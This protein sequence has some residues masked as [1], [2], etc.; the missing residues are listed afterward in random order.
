MADLPLTVTNVGRTALAAAIASGTNLVVTTQK[1]GQGQ[2]T[3]DGDEIDIMTPFVPVREQMDPAGSSSG[4]TLQFVFQD[5]SSDVYD[6][7]EIGWF[8][9]N[10]LFGISSR[11]SSEGWLLQKG[12]LPLVVP[13]VYDLG[14]VPTGN[15]VFNVTNQFPIATEQTPGLVQRA[16]NTQAL[17]STN[18]AVFM[19]PMRTDE[20]FQSKEAS[21]NEYDTNTAGKWIASN[22]SIL[23]T[24]LKGT[25]SAARF[26]RASQTEYNA[27]TR[28]DLLVTANLDVPVAKLTGSIPV[29]LFPN[30]SIGN[31]SLRVTSS[32]QSI[33]GSKLNPHIANV[34]DIDTDGKVQLGAG[35][36]FPVLVIDFIPT[37]GGDSRYVYS[38]GS[39]NGL[40]LHPQGSA[41]T[42]SSGDKIYL[43]DDFIGFSNSS[44]DG[45][46][47][48]AVIDGDS[49][50]GIYDVIL[51]L[52]GAFTLGLVNPSV[53][54]LVNA[55]NIAWNWNN[56]EIATLVITGNRTLSV[57]TN[58]RN[59]SLYL[60][61][62]TQDSIGTRT[63][64][65][66]ASIAIGE[67]PA[68]VLS[69]TGGRTDVLGFMKWNGT[70]NYMGILKGY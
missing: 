69:T 58:G 33:G 54:S 8:S 50:T 30:R 51:D 66:H 52:F 13:S 38:S 11:P 47:V 15:I 65:L 35:T 9:G 31:A 20:Y 25:I 26:P 16:S 36:N 6:I 44:S 60:L 29:S 67:S 34:V 22:L 57:P 46:P 5:P 18:N 27:G 3:P 42:Y 63:L 43:R 14:D 61:R 41:D 62:I 28:D 1:S 2:Y 40:K 24:K 55:T 10:V 21:Q 12:G 4:T 48:G 68:P 32:H 23:A 19:T 70:V 17:D 64:A 39:F 59:N 37:A 45:R 7:G 49:L 56:G 53:Q